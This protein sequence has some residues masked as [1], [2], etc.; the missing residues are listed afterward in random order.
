[1]LL[2]R[3]RTRWGWMLPALTGC[4]MGG[5]VILAWVHPATDV[6]GALLLAVAALASVRA[7][8]LGMWASD[9]QAQRVVG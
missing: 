8:G 6:I 5:A 2:V 9:R 3:P 1:V 7:A 4:L